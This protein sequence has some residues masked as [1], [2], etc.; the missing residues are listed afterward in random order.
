LIEQSHARLDNRLEYLN[1]PHLGPESTIAKGEWQLW[2]DKLQLM[3][4][5]EQWQELFVAT[6]ELLR[7]ARTNTD[8]QITESRYS[9]WIVW[10]NFRKSAK[11]LDQKESVNRYYF[12]DT[13]VA[14]DIL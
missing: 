7:R 10:D 13:I 6:G 9:D 4:D 1:N 8:G 14:N 12:L 3:S 2:I 5:G 11:N